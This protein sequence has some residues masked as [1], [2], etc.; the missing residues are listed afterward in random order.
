MA[1]LQTIFKVML[2]ES[3]RLDNQKYTDEIFNSVEEIYEVYR[4]DE[5][6]EILQINLTEG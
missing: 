4:Q 1:I 6:Q 3:L 5:I 2:I